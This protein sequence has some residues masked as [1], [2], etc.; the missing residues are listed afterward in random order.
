MQPVSRVL[1]G[2]VVL[3]SG[4]IGSEH[5]GMTRETHEEEV[6]MMQC[7]APGNPPQPYVVSVATSSKGAPTVDAGTNWDCRHFRRHAQHDMMPVGLT[8]CRGDGAR[9]TVE[10]TSMIVCVHACGGTDG[11]RHAPNDLPRRV[12]GL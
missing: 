2:L 7:A 3:L 5:E 6:V 10:N 9:D 11:T 12:S 4:L 1:V 8:A